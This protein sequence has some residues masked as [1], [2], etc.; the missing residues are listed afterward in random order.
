[1][2]TMVRHLDG[3]PRVKS[4]FGNTRGGTVRVIIQLTRLTATVAEGTR[5]NKKVA[6]ECK[7]LSEDTRAYPT[8][9]NKMV[10]ASKVMTLK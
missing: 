5:T 6:I 9:L 3:M 2:T 7:M 10:T 4:I 8:I 1:M